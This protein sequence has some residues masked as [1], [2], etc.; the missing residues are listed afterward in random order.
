PTVYANDRNIIRAKNKLNKLKDIEIS[1]DFNDTI[2]KLKGAQLRDMMDFDEKEGFV[3]KDSEIEHY[4]DDLK[5]ETDTYD[6]A[7]TINTVENKTL[8]LNAVDYGWEIDKQKTVELI[9]ITLDD[10]ENKT[11]EPVYSKQAKSRLKNDIQDEYIEIDQQNKTL[12]YINNY[13][14][15]K[16]IPI[17]ITQPLP[18]G[19]YNIDTKTKGY[20]KNYTLGFYRHTISSEQNSDIQ[21]NPNLLESIYYD[22]TDNIAVIVY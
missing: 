12:Y 7:H 3:Y 11:I 15:T 21:A 17:K 18:K 19:I 13:K 20:S 22:V 16:S 1:F 5:K 9:K 8:T 10:A 6:K 4:V 14:I 2:H